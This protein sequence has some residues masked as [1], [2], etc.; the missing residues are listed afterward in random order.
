MTRYLI[1]TNILVRFLVNDDAD[2]FAQ[3]VQLFQQAAD[4]LCE[5]VITDVLIAE[6]AWVVT[7]PKLYALDRSDVADKLTAFTVQPGI[8]CQ[9]SPAL[10]DALRRFKDTR[11]GFF[12][13]YLAALAAASGDAVASFDKD[14]RKF[15][16]VTIWKPGQKRK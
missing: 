4:G 13:C 1:D 14:I 7:S 15:K 2:Q 5:I 11:C 8:R 9:N 12:D 10:L 6:T 16:D 3:V